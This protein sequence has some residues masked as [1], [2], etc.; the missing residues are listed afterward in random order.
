MG[1][2][3]DKESTIVETF[4]YQG[5]LCLIIRMDI[6]YFTD[7]YGAFHNGYVSVLEENHGKHYDSFPIAC[8]ELS[9]SGDLQMFHEENPQMKGHWFVGFSSRPD[10]AETKTRAAVKAR[11]LK[12][13]DELIVKE[14]HA[15]GG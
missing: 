7:R 6:A 12:L 1:K 3:K 11:T 5:R 13:A 4:E 10:K 8:E 14:T 2:A 9:F 15:V